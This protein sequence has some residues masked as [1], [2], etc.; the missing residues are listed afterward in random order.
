M[1]IWNVLE[2]AVA[3]EL[4]ARNPLKDRRIKLPEARK[5]GPEDIPSFEDIRK[6]L[7]HLHGPRPTV[8]GQHKL[9]WAQRLPMVALAAFAGLRVGECAALDWSRVDLAKREIEIDKKRGGYNRVDGIKGPKSETSARTIPMNPILHNIMLRYAALVGTTGPVFRN[10]SGGARRNY[11]A[12]GKQLKA[13]K[14]GAGVSGFSFHGLR[15]FAGSAWLAQGMRI[16][17]VSW[18]L[19]H[20]QITTTMGTYAHQLKEDDH[21]RRVLNEQVTRFP[22]IPHSLVTE[23]APVEEI[24]PLLPALT[25][26]AELVPLTT[27]GPIYEPVP[28]ADVP[29]IEAVPTVEI[30]P[31]RRNGSAMR[32]ACCKRAGRSSTW[33]RRSATTKRGCGVCSRTL[34]LTLPETSAC[35]PAGLGLC[36]CAIMASRPRKRRGYATWMIAA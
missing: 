20:A 15:H 9:N 33:R 10:S 1:V 13:A 34:G 4:L 32:C 31:R 28:L 17:D 27:S 3:E 19:G 22:G 8:T 12:F 16:Q 5:R 25:D 23:P 18:L 26:G 11:D 24:V 7:L 29:A 35:R 6:L 14:A 2:Y 36:I 21:A 30:P